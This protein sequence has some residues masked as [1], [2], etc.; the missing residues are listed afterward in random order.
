MVMGT[1]QVALKRV[2]KVTT[3]EPTLRSHCSKL[4]CLAY[5][6]RLLDP[7]VNIIV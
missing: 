5:Q 3:A 2:C 1:L 6:L 7:T 4:S